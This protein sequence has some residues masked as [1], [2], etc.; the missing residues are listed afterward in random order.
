MN[1]FR[2]YPEDERNVL[3]P[4]LEETVKEFSRIDGAFIIRGDGV[5]MSMGS[6]IETAGTPALLESGLGARHT[7]AMAITT[8]T[9]ALSI[10]ISESTHRITLFKRG[11][12]VM[13]LE[14][15]LR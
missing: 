6:Y 1:P 15:A 2:G 4:S 12:L 10:V 7:A 5:I 9:Q 14:Q 8:S 3:D 13:A 11:K